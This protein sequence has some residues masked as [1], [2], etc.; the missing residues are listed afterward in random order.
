MANTNTVRNQYHPDYVS[1]PGETLL[2]TLEVLGM[3]QAE[4]AK[5]M[6]RP[7][8]TVNEIIQA[9]AAITEETALQ[10]ERVLH[11]AAEFWLKREQHYRESLVRLAEDR[12]LKSW[13]SWLKE[14]PIREMMRRGWIPSSTDKAHQVLEALKFFGVASP[15]AWLAMWE[16]EILPGHESEVSE[17]NFGVV[18][19]WLRQGEVA[20]QEIDCTPYSVEKF[21]EALAQMRVLGVNSI[22]IFQMELVRLCANAG[23]AVV[24]VQE[25]PGAGVCGA[26][27]WLTSVK[28]L[29][30]LGVRYKTIE[31]LRSAFLRGADHILHGGKRQFFLESEC[32]SAEVHT[33]E[34]NIST[35]E[36]LKR[37]SQVLE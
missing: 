35:S 21:R 22:E 6:G 28:A 9:K 12:R 23:V 36:A 1:P 31:Q 8:K 5:R 29:V 33:D 37:R 17:S 20:A 26:T 30:Q 10:L 7:T 13:V 32:D 34:V 19:A 15:D 4:L 25:L 24:F 16:N 11:I 14:I 27:Q 2:E 18:T 3:S